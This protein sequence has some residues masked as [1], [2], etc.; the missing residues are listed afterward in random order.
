MP[1]NVFDLRLVGSLRPLPGILEDSDL[2]CVKLLLRPRDAIAD[3][4]L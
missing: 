3:A 2:L 1:D 4:D